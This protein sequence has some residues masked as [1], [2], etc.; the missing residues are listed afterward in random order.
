M[1]PPQSDVCYV[2]VGVLKNWKQF[3]VCKLFRI[4]WGRSAAFILISHLYI[5]EVPTK[6][7]REKI[8]VPRNI[9]EKKIR[10]HEI[11]TRRNF[12][13]TKYPREKNSDPRRHGDTMARDPRDPRWHETHG[14]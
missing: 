2:K 13:P 5:H 4:Y 6:H 11:S 10:T 3:Y 14:I 12:G 8:L 9:H 7:P 1:P